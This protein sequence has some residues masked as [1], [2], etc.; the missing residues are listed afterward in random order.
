VPTP[1][2]TPTPAPAPIP[3]VVNIPQANT[4]NNTSCCKHCSKGKA[5]GDSCISKSYTCSKP[6]GCACNY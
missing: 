1:V 5:C 2:T 3:A 6:P 4:T